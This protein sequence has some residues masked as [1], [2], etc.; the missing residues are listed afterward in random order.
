MIY[1]RITV[2]TLIQ[3]DAEVTEFDYDECLS[4]FAFNKAKKDQK[5][6]SGFLSAIRYANLELQCPLPD[7]NYKASKQKHG[8]TKVILKIGG[9]APYL[10]L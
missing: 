7:M 8:K 1:N 9:D 10:C 6:S 5:G 2:F 4:G 3:S